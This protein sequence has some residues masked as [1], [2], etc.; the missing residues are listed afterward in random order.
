MN[1]ALYEFTVSDHFSLSP[2]EIW[3]IAWS[4]AKE[5][6]DFWGCMG[7]EF[8][9]YSVTCI[10]VEVGE[11]I[12]Y[13]FE[14]QEVGGMTPAREHAK[15]IAVL[16]ALKVPDFKIQS[17]LGG[18]TGVAKV[19]PTG[20]LDMWSR[21]GTNILPEDAVELGHWLIKTFGEEGNGEAHAATKERG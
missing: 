14:M 3:E 12:R 4:S 7:E 2:G 1:R 8:P 19:S 13:H 18:L 15:A 10:K 17:I 5:T 16:A 11:I 9:R 21:G 20:H 6:A